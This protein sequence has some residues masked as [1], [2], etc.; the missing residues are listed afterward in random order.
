MLNEAAGI[1]LS[2]GSEAETD[3]IGDPM[4]SNLSASDWDWDKAELFQPSDYDPVELWQSPSLQPGDP[5]LFPT[6]SFET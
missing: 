4:L 2:G 5:D 6:I 1:G 3:N